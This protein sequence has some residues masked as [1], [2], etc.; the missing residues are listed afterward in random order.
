MAFGIGDKI[1]FFFLFS[2][3]FS[4]FCLQIY[5]DEKPE[6]MGSNMANKQPPQ[7]VLEWTRFK[8]TLLW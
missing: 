4:P 5:A 3:I 1:F 6:K 7:S 2:A 8:Q